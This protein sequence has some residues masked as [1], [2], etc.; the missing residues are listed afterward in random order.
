MFRKAR[1]VVSNLNTKRAIELFR[2]DFD[3]TRRG[4]RGNSVANGILNDWLQN[5]VRDFGVEGLFAQIH[6]GDQAILET[7]ALDL[8]ITS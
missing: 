8:E 2:F 3:Q 4:T 7:D 5:E 1:A 6:A